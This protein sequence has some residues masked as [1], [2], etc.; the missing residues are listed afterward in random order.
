VGQLGLD[1]KYTRER[2]AIKGAGIGAGRHDDDLRD[3]A[4]QAAAEQA[5]SELENGSGTK[6]S[7]GCHAR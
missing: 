3:D 6:P 2:V 7:A 5:T 4:S 1:G